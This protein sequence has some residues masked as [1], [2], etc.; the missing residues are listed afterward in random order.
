LPLQERLERHYYL[1]S[2]PVEDPLL[3]SFAGEKAGIRQD[4]KVL[5]TLPINDV[6][7]N[8]RPLG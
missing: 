1:L 2:S 5:A 7:V 8:K 4:P 6:M 3:D